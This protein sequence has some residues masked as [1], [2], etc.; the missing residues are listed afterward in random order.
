MN[1]STL[2][3]NALKARLRLLVSMLK[4]GPGK[5]T[6]VWF[7]A[8]AFSQRGLSVVTVDADLGS[9][10]LSGWYDTAKA[11][12]YEVPFAV[13]VW[14]GE[15]KDGSLSDFLS[16]LEMK[17]AGAHVFICD[18]GGERR[19]VFMSACLWADRLLSP[20]GPS[21]LEIQQ[22]HIT[23]AYAN[24]VAKYSPLVMSVV[25][26]RVPSIGR[27]LAIDARALITDEEK[28]DANRQKPYGIHVTTT[29]IAE[30]RHKYSVPYGRVT[31]DTGQFDDLA[32][33]L[34]DEQHDEE[35][36]QA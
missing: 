36:Q 21:E 17:Y 9:R 18:T 20:C 16:M 26:N 11:D 25:L 4:G 6:M 33:E 35:E 34:I 1:P 10:T 2:P 23:K 12:G 24:D 14:R 3:R 27:G 29:E 19:E 13:E 5:T 15:E 28:T 30:S 7:L 31:D 8:T 22:L 32:Q